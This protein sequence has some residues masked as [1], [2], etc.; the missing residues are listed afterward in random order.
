MRAASKTF[1]AALPGGLSDLTI[2]F[3]QLALNFDKAFYYDAIS[4]QEHD[5]SVADYQTRIEPEYEQFDK[6]RAL[7][8]FHVSLGEIKG[9]GNKRR[10]KRVDV[11]LAVDMLTHSFR[12]N[13]QSATLLAGDDDFIPLVEALVREG[14]QI[15]IWHPS[16]ASSELLGSADNRRPLNLGNFL[17]LLTR[18]GIQPAFRI[19]SGGGGSPGAMGVG[20][21]SW[22]KDGKQHHAEFVNDQLTVYRQYDGSWQFQTMQCPGS[23]K[24]QA[25]A[26]FEAL[27]GWEMI[28][29]G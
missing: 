8:K 26:A 6:I 18:D 29:Q 21:W 2:D 14:L 7:D 25:C 24:L 15:T 4:A 28:A 10:Q 1:S 3:A 17:R 5:E 16:Q 27:T 9:R 22:V 19:A 23:P 12:K 11:K 20:H 13:M